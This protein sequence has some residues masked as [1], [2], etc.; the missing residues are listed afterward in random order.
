MKSLPLEMKEEKQRVCPWWLGYFLINPLRRYRHNPENILIPYI[1]PGMK[2]M[3]YGCAMGY[4]SLPMA[5]L[6][7]EDGKIYC[8]DVQKKM[9][10][11]LVKR[12]EKADLGH[13]IDARLVDKDLDISDLEGMIDFFLLF[14]VVHE[15][16]DKAGLFEMLNMLAKPGARILFAEPRGHVNSDAFHHSVSLAEK[17]GFIA[18]RRITIKGSHALTLRKDF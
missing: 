10:S 5:R 8:M 17:S 16:P 3:D 4:F 13:L 9:L 14:A 7:G 15:V 12:A 2:I 18:E 1:R 11:R 6:T